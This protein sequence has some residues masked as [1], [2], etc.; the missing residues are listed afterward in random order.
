MLE[1]ENFSTCQFCSEVSKANGEDPIGTAA[2][3]DCWLVVEMA[4]PWTEKTFK[5]DLRIVPLLEL[6]KQLFLK[7][8]IA[9]RPIL[10]APDLEYSKPGSGR[11]IFYKRPQA[12]FAQFSKQ[13]FVLPEADVPRLATAILRHLLKQPNELDSFQEFRQE[14]GHIREILICTHGNVDVACSRFGYPIYKKLREDY[15]GEWNPEGSERRIDPL[16]ELRVWRCSHFGGHK[17]APTLIDLPDGRYWGH[18]EPE[19]LDIL[20]YR[21]GNLSKLRSHY[22]GWSG[23]YKHEQIAERSLWEKEGWDWLSR[24]ISGR[25]RSKGLRGIKR[26]LYPLLKSIPLKRS[27]A[28]AEL[29]TQDAEWAEVQIQCSHPERETQTVYDVRI[30]AFGQVTT[31]ARSSKAG[32]NIELVTVPQYRVTHLSNRL[33]PL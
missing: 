20:I 4:P 16:P 13:E 32:K 2:T 18:L 15:A 10:I 31:A 24:D 6:F 1:Q 26:Y 14:S 22:R 17:F 30:E 3:V 7:Q 11:V 19:I 9:I 12:Q 33:Q 28:F 8:G 29:W 21:Q 5:E 25:T 27:R 23:L